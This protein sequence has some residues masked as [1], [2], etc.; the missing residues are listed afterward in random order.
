MESNTEEFL[1]GAHPVLEAL[2]AGKRPARELILDERSGDARL[3]PL[4][5]AAAKRGVPVRRASKQVLFE[6]CDSKQHQGAVLRTVPFPYSPLDDAV[7]EQRRLLLLDNIED[8][9]NAGAILRSA[10][11]FGFTTI[12]LPMRG[13]SEIYPSVAKTSAGATEHVNV[14]RAANS[15]RYV[16]RARE[17]G[18]RIVALDMHGT[19]KLAEIPAQDVRPLLLV[20]GGEDK[21]IGQ[22]ILNEAD[23]VA[24]IP[25]HGRVTSLNASV[26]AGIALYHF[27]A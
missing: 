20:I 24:S 13:A 16:Q 10:E 15:N 26:A 25:Q 8:P 21:R 22:F 7:F 5:Q 2:V 14:I 18:Y 17:C 11:I 4:E 1:Y 6:L 27:T 23:V 19:V 9:R 12:L 3:K